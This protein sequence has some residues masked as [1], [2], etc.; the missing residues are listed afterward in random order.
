MG[1]ADLFR[2]PFGERAWRNERLTVELLD[3]TAVS[4]AADETGPVNGPQQIDRLG[5]H[6]ARRDVTAK[7]DEVRLFALHLAQHR[8]QGGQVSVDVSQRRD[9]HQLSAWGPRSGVLSLRP[10]PRSRTGRRA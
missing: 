6:R 5:R 4:V 9:P 1:V 3:Q 7:H 8:F 10:P 2:A